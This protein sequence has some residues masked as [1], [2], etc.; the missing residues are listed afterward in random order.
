MPDLRFAELLDGVVRLRP[1]H[2]T[3]VEGV[4]RADLIGWLGIY[5]ALTPGVEGAVSASVRLDD[6][7]M[8]QPN[9]S[10]RVTRRGLTHVAADGI[11]TGPP[12]LVAVVVLSAGFWAEA[13]NA[14]YR[15]HGVPEYLV[16]R[17]DDGAV[18]WF[19]LRPGGY[20]PLPIGADG[21]I[22][23]EVFP[24]LWLDPAALL[25]GD[26]SALLRAAQLGHG[27][28]EHAAF[29]RRLAGA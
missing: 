29:V 3:A 20:E 8:T 16:W 24:G 28:P 1:P 19:A 14:V 7:D 4:A 15:K 22:R 2:V 11:L 10:L 27:S 6:R 12:E 13:K 23:S 25:A 26:G 17:V 9:A 21:L 5:Q 18:D